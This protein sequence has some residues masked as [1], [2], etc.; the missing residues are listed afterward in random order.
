MAQAEQS[1][2]FLEAVGN[3]LGNGQPLPKGGLS[4]SRFLLEI[5]GM[6]HVNQHIGFV[7]AVL[8]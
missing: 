8:S 1:E 6:A 7:P 5:I 3:L 4:L 2:G